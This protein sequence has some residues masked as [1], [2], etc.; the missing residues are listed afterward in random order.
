MTALGEKRRRR[1]SRRWRRRLQR[2][3]AGIRARA[4]GRVEG[5]DVEEA[6]KPGWGDTMRKKRGR[7]KNKVVFTAGAKARSEHPSSFF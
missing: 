1:K 3:H 7:K 2:K 5:D 6:G 4:G